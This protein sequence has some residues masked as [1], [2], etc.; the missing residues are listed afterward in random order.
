[1]PRKPALVDLD[2][3]TITVHPLNVRRQLGDLRPLTRSVKE[4]GVRVPLIVVPDGDGHL[5]IAGHRRRQAALN[6]EAATVPCVVR[7]DIEGDADAI[8]DMLIENGN[9]EPLTAA[10]ESAAYEQLS[11]LGLSDAEIARRTGVSPK[12]VKKARTVAGSEVAT[13]VTERYDLTLDQALVIVEFEDDPAAVRDLTVTAR[14]DPG[15]FLHLASRFRQDRQA[16]QE[17]A[18][19]V[20][21]L[22]DAGVEVLDARGD[23]G[24]VSLR[25]LTDTDDGSPI[26]VKAHAKC[27]GHVAFVPQ[28][29]PDEPEF[30][31]T[32]PAT[33]GHRDRYATSGRPAPTPLNDDEKAKRR[34]VIENNKAWRAAEPVR[35]DFIRTVLARKTPPKCTLRFVTERIVGSPDRVGNGKD[36]LL[37][38]LLATETG[39]GYGRTVGS[40]LLAHVTDARLPL[41]LLAQ[42]AADIEQGTDVHCWRN[43]T[44]DVAGW[45]QFLASAGYTLSDIEQ[46]VIDRVIEKEVAAA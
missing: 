18:A 25:D 45:L 46:F 10:E 13:A 28:H 42:V 30:F 2:P 16:A 6:A 12:Y 36:D 44:S 34:E 37:A 41:A 39:N 4:R 22:R 21:A 9:R 17:H 11:V 19:A 3:R 8:A 24:A 15:R 32:D 31:C 20:N 33:N 5:L 29:R 43:P 26:T 35:R 40:A 1:M 38:D 7:H 27:P 23:R 14:K